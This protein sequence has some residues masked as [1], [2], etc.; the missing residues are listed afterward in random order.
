VIG[1]SV[2]PHSVYLCKTW[3]KISTPFADRHYIIIIII[4]GG[5]GVV[6]VVVAA[7][8]LIRAEEV[9]RNHW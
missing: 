1:T 2:I 5:G 7:A 3:W 8:A 9:K 4:G 6:V